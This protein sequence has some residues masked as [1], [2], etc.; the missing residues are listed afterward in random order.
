M[1]N[2][3]ENIWNK[4]GLKVLNNV[5]IN[6]LETH[7]NHVLDFFSH[8]LMMVTRRYFKNL[9]LH[10]LQS[11][12]EDLNTIAKL[13][14]IEA[15]KTWDPIHNEEVWPL[16][17]AKIVGAMKDHIRH[18]TKSDPTRV[19]EWVTHE[20]QNY[21]SAKSQ[22]D[23]VQRYDMKDE[24]QSAMKKLNERDR[25]IV[26]AHTKLDLTFKTIGEKINLSEAQVSRVFKKSMVILKKEIENS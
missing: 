4:I 26:Y 23:H 6:V 16:A 19:Y 2:I 18:L 13:E 20:A 8:R 10:V 11:E 22:V 17:Q 5:K 7:L 9:P 15:I 12:E 21:I 1:G 3:I 14:L 24:I 25:Y